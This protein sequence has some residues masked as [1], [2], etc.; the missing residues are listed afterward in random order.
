MAVDP[1]LNSAYQDARGTFWAG[2][3]C[4]PVEDD[5]YGYQINGVLVSDF[6]TPNWFAHRFAKGPYDFKQH[7]LGKFE[8]LSGGYAQ[9]FDPTKGWVQV[10]GPK[11]MMSAKYEPSEGSRRERRTRDSEMWV[12]SDAID[13]ALPD[14]TPVRA[15]RTGGARTA[16]G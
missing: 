10:T 4:D 7:A 16:R 15:A 5:Q 13:R 2:E 1:W 9:A 12:R 3:I 11:A 8:V 6:I 14:G